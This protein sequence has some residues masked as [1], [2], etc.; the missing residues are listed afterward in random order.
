MKELVQ[1]FNKLILWINELVLL[2]KE[3]AQS[4]SKLILWIKE[5]MIINFDPE[6]FTRTYVRDKM[7]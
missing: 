4:L 6:G 5:L 3:L 2:M 1:S 7:I